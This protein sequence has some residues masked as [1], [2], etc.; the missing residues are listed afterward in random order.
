VP[1][2]R[3]DELSGLVTPMLRLAIRFGSSIGKNPSN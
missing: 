3:L 1:L 2:S